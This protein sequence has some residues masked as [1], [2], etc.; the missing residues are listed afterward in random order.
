MQNSKFR[1]RAPQSARS[2]APSDQ[3][4]KQGSASKNANLNGNILK[5]KTDQLILSSARKVT[6][7]VETSAAILTTVNHQVVE[8]EAILEDD[9]S[10]IQKSPNQLSFLEFPIDLMSN[11]KQPEP[12]KFTSTMKFGRTNCYMNQKFNV[13][14]SGDENEEGEID[15]F[16]EDGNIVMSDESNIPESARIASSLLQ[17]PIFTQKSKN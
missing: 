16:T 5:S 9:N 12:V 6:K 1:L 4:K 8:S 7:L 14:E 11:E 15:C 13:M 3:R 2:D 17:T 10:R